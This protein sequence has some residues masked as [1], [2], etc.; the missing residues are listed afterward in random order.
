MQI[1]G[2]VASEDPRV[3]A[4][5]RRSIYSLDA[6]AEVTEKQGLKAAEKMTRGAGAVMFQICIFLFSV[7]LASMIIDF[8]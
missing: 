7:S 3:R 1:H 5:S 8:H 6:I 2:S 4:L